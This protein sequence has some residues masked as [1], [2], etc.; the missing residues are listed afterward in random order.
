MAWTR[1]GECNGCG[2]CCTTFARQP[3]VRDPLAVADQAFYRARGFKTVPIDGSDRLV[4]FA[5][6][7]AECPEHVDNGCR[8]YDD[9]PQ[10]C[11]SFPT[12]PADIAGTPCSYWF[13]DGAHRVGGAGSPH[14][15]TELQLLAI[16]AG[17]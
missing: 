10:T 14:P 1:H 8:I 2:F 11:K 12:V 3:I 7:Q 16:E 5:W 9:R 6:L 15:T 13:D 4:L 17:V